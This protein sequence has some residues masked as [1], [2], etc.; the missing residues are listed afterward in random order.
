[1]EDYEFQNLKFLRLKSLWIKE[2]N[3]SDN[4]YPRLEHFV[5]EKC[6]FLR[7]IPPSFVSISTLMIIEVNSHLENSARQIQEEQKGL[8]NDL[9]VLISWYCW[10]LVQRFMTSK[11]QLLRSF[12]F[13][14]DDYLILLLQNLFH[15]CHLPLSIENWFDTKVLQEYW[16]RI[17]LN[18]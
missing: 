16:W 18:V 14:Y 15:S 6:E 13:W 9:E 5:V 8:G 3:A 4:S 7:K 10:I 2:F 12:L 17:K 11:Q 1:M